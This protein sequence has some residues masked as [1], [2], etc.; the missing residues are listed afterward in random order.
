[1]LELGCGRHLL[2]AR[3]PAAAAPDHLDHDVGEEEEDGG[4]EGE[5]VEEEELV[6][7]E[8]VDGGAGVEVLR[9]AH[10]ELQPPHRA[11]KGSEKGTKSKLYRFP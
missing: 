9:V 5:D 4:E 2:L 10:Q 7:A 6:R 3:P 8:V 11:V 1:M